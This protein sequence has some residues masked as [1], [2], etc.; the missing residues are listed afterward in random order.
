MLYTKNEHSL[1]ANIGVRK[2]M[3][4]KK[5][6]NS[7]K[8]IS[9]ILATLLL[10]VIAVAAIVVTYAWITTY[11][12]SAQS[13]AGVILYT[14]NVRFATGTTEITVG[15][16]GTEDTRIVRLWLGDSSGNMTDVTANTDITGVGTALSAGGT[17][18]ITLDWPNGIDS[19]WTAGANYYFRVVP[20]PGQFIDFPDQA[21]LT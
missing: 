16:S 12:G 8:A 15:N 20:N 7:K 3:S 6:L 13:Q 9:P 18:T 11:M 17:A 14:E 5:L 19:T 10:I 2:K 1:K 21:P 4:I